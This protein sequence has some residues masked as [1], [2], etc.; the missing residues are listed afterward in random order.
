MP[1]LKTYKCPEH[2]IFEAWQAKCPQGC[3][4]VE[5]VIYVKPIAVRDSQKTSKSKF[6]DKTAK[7]LAKDFKMTNIKSTKEGEA[8]DNYAS[9]NNVQPQPRPGDGVI[10]G[11]AGRFS[12]ASVLKG[13]TVQSVAGEPVGVSPKDVNITRGPR[14]ASYVA[15]HENLQIKK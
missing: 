12:M 7:G 13:G 4:K 14:A 10:W 5:Q 2:G 11:D 3:K 15:D 9:R 6:A 8:Q 1:I